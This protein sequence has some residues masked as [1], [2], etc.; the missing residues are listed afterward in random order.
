MTRISNQLFLATAVAI[1]GAS[2]ANAQA[3]TP[4]GA[5]GSGDSTKISNSNREN[6]SAY[7]HVVG[8]GVKSTSAED[9]PN[10]RN[11][12]HSAATPATVADIKTGSALRDK[13]GVKIGTIDSVD[14]DGAIVNTG[15]T[16]I[17]VPIVAFGKDDQGLLLGITAA[18][19]NELVGKAHSSSN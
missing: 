3:G 7:N 17:K 4:S 1:F 14:A 13:D 16:K 10:A 15:Q 19:F 18:R 5:P 2:M 12:K 8:T 11:A 9:Q 6:N